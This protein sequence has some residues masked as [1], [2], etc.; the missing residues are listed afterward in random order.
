MYG[1]HFREKGE[2]GVIMYKDKCIKVSGEKAREM[3]SVGLG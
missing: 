3:E 1:S 2:G